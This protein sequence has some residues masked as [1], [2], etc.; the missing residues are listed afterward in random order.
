[1]ARFVAVDGEKG[2]YAFQAE[3]MVE[4]GVLTDGELTC[5]VAEGGILYKVD[6]TLSISTLYED[7]AVI[8]SQEA[9]ERLCAGRSFWRDVPMFDYL[10]PRQV[11]VTACEFEY[12]TD[13]KGF[14]PASL[15]FRPLG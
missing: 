6:N 2:K 3:Y 1:M 7:V 9:Y 8:S 15:L 4:D 12:L 11:R 14:P 13:S 5:S 10:T